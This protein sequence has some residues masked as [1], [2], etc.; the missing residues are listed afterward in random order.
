MICVSTSVIRSTNSSPIGCV[1]VPIEIYTNAVI[2]SI[3]SPVFS[4]EPVLKLY[5]SDYI[6]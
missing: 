3:L 4:P 6:E 5:L 2:I 1:V